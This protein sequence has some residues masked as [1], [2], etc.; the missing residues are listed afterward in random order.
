MPTRKPIKAI[1]TA[2]AVKIISAVAPSLFE[3]IFISAVPY[4]VYSFYV[5]L[6]LGE[7]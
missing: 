7:R 5:I 3:L 2:A 1:S 6:V 4:E